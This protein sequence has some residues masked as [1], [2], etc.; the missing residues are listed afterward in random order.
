VRESLL[1]A[2]F[3]AAA[4]NVTR[5]CACLAGHDMMSL[6]FSYLD[7]MLFVF[8]SDGIIV[9]DVKIQDFDPVSFKIRAWW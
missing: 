5:V 7:E 8:C 1:C 6:L 4:M 9:K 2:A 3:T